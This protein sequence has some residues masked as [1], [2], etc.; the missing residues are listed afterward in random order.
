MRILWLVLV[1]LAGGL[2]LLV[3]NH[4]EG[5]VF[6]LPNSVF[7][8][9]LYLGLWASALIVGMMGSGMRL[10]ATA[11]S[12]AFW[13]ALLV[14][15]MALYQYR[16]EI[17]DVASRVTAGLVP[18]SPVALKAK[19]GIARVM[20]ER[21]INGHFEII[22]HVNGKAVRMLIDTGASSIVLSASDARSAGF[23]TETLDYRI[24][25]STA[26]GSTFVARE[27]ASE[28]R[29]GSIFRHEIPVYI[30][31]PGSLQQS[32]LGMS[33]INTLSAFELRGDRVILQD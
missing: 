24:P 14:A 20:V 28:V 32:L 25:V 12:F 30:A 3:V 19:D 26:N 6:G 18:G 15:L 21:A 4:D 8:G 31:R 7:A 17:Q 29:I 33:F 5:Q 2:V 22:A 9:T 23:V 16:Y 11:R 1:V 10:G 27:E 13:S